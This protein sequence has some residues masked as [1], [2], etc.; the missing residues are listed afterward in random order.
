VLGLCS[1]NCPGLSSGNLG[2]LASA[3]ESTPLSASF[4]AITWDRENFMQASEAGPYGHYPKCVFPYA[5]RARLALQG[6][7]TKSR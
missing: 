1:N 7:A 4:R 3:G 5:I 6:I 2:V